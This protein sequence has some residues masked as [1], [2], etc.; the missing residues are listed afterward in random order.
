MLKSTLK[1]EYYIVHTVSLFLVFGFEMILHSP[2]SWE[3]PE[4]ET[5]RPWMR[6]SKGRHTFIHSIIYL[7]A[8]VMQTS[9]LPFIFIFKQVFP[10]ST[11]SSYISVKLLHFCHISLLSIRVVFHYSNIAL[12]IYDGIIHCLFDFMLYF[13][14]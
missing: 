7:F 9:Y 10:Y 13:N 1:T 8:P 6:S 12:L 14:H 11:L 3:R 5:L 4:A 2:S